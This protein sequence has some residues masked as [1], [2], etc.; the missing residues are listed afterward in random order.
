[1]EQQWTCPQCSKTIT[2][3]DTVVFARDR[4]THFYCRWPR[5]LSS[6][7]RALLFL[8]C[9]DHAVAECPTCA[10]GYRQTELASDLFSGR[11]QQ[12]PQCRAELID[13]VRAHLYNCAMLPA[14]VRRQAQVA[15]ETSRALV[16]RGRQL[17]DRADV[18]MREAEA[19]LFA[20]RETTRKLGK[21]KA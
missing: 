11:E 8:F 16:K 17:A 9:W 12:C 15:R 3:E 19:A 7:E 2:T 18:L 20:L 1:M 21:R 5:V 13:S 14:E 4:I 6:E 10:K